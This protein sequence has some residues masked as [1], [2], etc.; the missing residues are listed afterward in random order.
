MFSVEKETFNPYPANIKIIGIGGAGGN[1]VNRMIDFK[2]CGVDFIAANTDVQALKRSNASVRVQLGEKIT[3]GLGVGGDPILGEKAAN[4][5]IE[6]IKEI[7][8]GTDMI[9]LTAGMG[10]GTGTGAAPIFAKVAREFN[11]LTVGVVTF[12]FAYEGKVREARAIEGISKL[13]ENF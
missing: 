11:I 5:D 9:F 4:E 3:K 7:I 6:R 12:P 8:S 13:K 1:A 10:G 2:L